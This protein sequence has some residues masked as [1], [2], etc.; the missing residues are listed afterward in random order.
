[1]LL[2]S[3]LLWKSKLYPIT[4]CSGETQTKQKVTDNSEACQM[5]VCKGFSPL[6]LLEEI[7]HGFDLLEV[8]GHVSGQNHLDH[9]R[10]ELS[11]NTSTQKQLHW[12]SSPEKVIE[13]CFKVWGYLFAFWMRNKSFPYR[14]CSK[15]SQNFI[16]LSC[17][18]VF[19]LK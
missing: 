11:K 17:F 3:L 7:L 2:K 16:R 12:I 9:E 14:S 10:P 1:M 18:V 5:S 13:F 8:A 6:R 19:S 15:T 4:S